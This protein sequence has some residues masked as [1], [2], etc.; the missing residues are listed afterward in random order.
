MKAIRCG[1]LILIAV[2]LVGL[3]SVYAQDQKGKTIVSADKTSFLRIKRDV[4]GDP[5]CMQT[6]IVRYAP[7]DKTDTYVDLVGAVHVGEKSY[8]AQLNDRFENYD[9]VLYELVAPKKGM[10]PRPGQS[11]DNPLA[12]VLKIVTGVFQWELQLECVDYTPKH[13]VHADLTYTEMAEILRKRGDN[14]FTIGLSVIADILRKQNLQQ[15]EQ[16]PG[17]AEPDPEPDIVEFLSDLEAPAKIKRILAEESVKA[18]DGSGLGPTLDT[19]LIADRNAA[20]MKVLAEQLKAGKKRIAIF[21]GAAHM[22]D[23]EKRLGREYGMQRQSTDWVTAWD[24]RL[25]SFN[26][27]ELLLK[28]SE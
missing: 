12:F 10:I 25:R 16:Q 21:Y 19:L 18:G 1:I 26:P 2:I 6:A 11:S 3:T 17:R 22:P 23:F 9:V 5:L 7:A 14:A 4:R 13:F 24:L 28:L 27:L 8:Y 15:E 20:C